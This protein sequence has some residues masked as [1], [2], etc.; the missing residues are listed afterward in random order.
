MKLGIKHDFNHVN[1]ISCYASN[2]T[3]ICDCTHSLAPIMSRRKNI[4]KTIITQVPIMSR[5]K[6]INKL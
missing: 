5:K 1:I 6:N 2:N 3:L 4:K